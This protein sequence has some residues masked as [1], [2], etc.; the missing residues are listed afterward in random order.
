[1]KEA[2]TKI[3]AGDIGRDMVHKLAVGQGRSGA[4]RQSQ[5]AIVDRSDEATTKQDASR[6]ASVE[7]VVRA[8]RRDNLEG[9]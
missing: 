8:Q 9:K 2:G 4:S 5:G 3:D 6:C 1:M 7:E